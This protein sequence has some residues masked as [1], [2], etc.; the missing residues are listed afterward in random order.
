[1]VFNNSIKPYKDIFNFV[2]IFK[3]VKPNV[4]GEVIN[5]DDIVFKTIMLGE[6]HTSHKIISSG[7]EE[8]S[9]VEEKDSLW[10]LL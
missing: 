4:F 5:K 7:C 1:V 6:V 10:L 8:I 9:E 2:F 3:W